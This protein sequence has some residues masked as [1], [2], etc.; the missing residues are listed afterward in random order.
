M[1]FLIKTVV[2]ALIIAVVATVSKRL[3]TLGAII[4]SLPITSMIAIIW[5]YRDT[6]DAGKVIDL[7]MSIFWVVVPSVVFFVA[8]AV[9]LKRNVNFYLSMTISSAVMAITYYVYINILRCFKIDI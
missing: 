2:S 3:P 4:A 5:L 8:L 1:Q 6:K 7:S 9:L